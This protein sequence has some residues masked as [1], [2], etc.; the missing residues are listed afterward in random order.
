M[1]SKWKYSK[2]CKFIENAI[3]DYIPKRYVDVIFDSINYIYHVKIK[4]AF[5]AAE[6]QFT[7]SQVMTYGVNHVVNMIKHDFIFPKDGEE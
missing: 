1:D 5:G 6:Y 2:V 4:N 3:D 7:W